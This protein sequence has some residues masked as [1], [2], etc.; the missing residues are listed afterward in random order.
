MLKQIL[1][2]SV[3]L[4]NDNVFN[5]FPYL[6]RVLLCLVTG[7]SLR[8]MVVHTRFQNHINIPLLTQ[9]PM[10][11]YR[12]ITFFTQ[13]FYSNLQNGAH[14]LAKYKTNRPRIIKQIKSPMK[15]R[16]IKKEVVGCYQSEY[17][18][19]NDCLL[20]YLKVKSPQLILQVAM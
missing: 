13:L 18:T 20:F 16:I 11:K 1:L 7:N 14:D 17:S 10:F 15:E 6:Y 2:D 3:L 9:L 12:E 19:H 8:N 4:K 5:S